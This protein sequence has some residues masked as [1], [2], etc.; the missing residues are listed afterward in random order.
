MQ[1]ALAK[2]NEIYLNVVN[3]DNQSLST[4]APSEKDHPG[5][6]LDF[7]HNL[8]EE[9]IRIDLGMTLNETLVSEVSFHYEVRNLN[10]FYEIKEGNI[11]NFNNGFISQ[12]CGISYATLRGLLLVCT[13]NKSNVLLPIIDPIL[14]V[15]TFQNKKKLGFI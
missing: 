11:V 4:F 15:E 5:I 13:E 6:V 14:I 10:R 9:L 8:E 1:Q 2:A 12:L 3:Y 7:A